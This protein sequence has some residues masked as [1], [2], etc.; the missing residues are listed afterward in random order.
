MVMTMSEEYK[1]ST[2]YKDFLKHDAPVEFL[3]G[4]TATWQNYS[5]NTQVYAKG[6]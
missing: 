3:E 2:K 1:L 5:R 6:S 4:T